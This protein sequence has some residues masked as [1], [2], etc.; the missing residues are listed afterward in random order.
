M[1]T[2]VLI[3]QTAFIG[4]VVLV[5]P[6]IQAAKEGLE[7]DLV[8]VLV[9]PT[10]AE[11]LY[12]NPCVDEIIPYDKKETQKG[13][14]GL[15]AMAGRLSTVP[16][17]TALIPHRSMRSA[18][19][20]WLARIPERVG[21]ASSEG[22]WLLTRRIPYECVHEVDRNLSLLSPWHDVNPSS[23]PPVLYP[24]DGDRAF[25]DALLHRQG[26][27]SSDR[28]I[29]VNPG[30]IWATKRW[31]P[32][33]FADIVRRVEQ[34]MDARAVLFG[35]WEDV[36][37]CR[38]IASQSGAKPLIAAGEATLLQSAALVERCAALVSNDSAMVHIAAAM[39]TPVV[40]IFGPTIPAFGFTPYGQGHCSIE[41][42]LAC[43][44]CG[45]HGSANCPIGTH[46]CM[47]GI[48]SEQV[49]EALSDMVGPNT[50]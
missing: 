8:S 31:R 46:E 17:D 9:R 26:F 21:F 38:N 13:L 20:A 43:R 6:L 16:F 40:D 37:L 23:Y 50:G 48:T 19:L 3:I 18:F 27:V 36:D 15:M 1:P 47:T 10:A 32:E 12:N 30:S 28:L 7:A 41:Y 29:G 49:F 34:D 45:R 42:N 44:P 25:V 14:S 33:R 2:R 39:G 24:D 35:G 22:R 11:L 5:T 4:D